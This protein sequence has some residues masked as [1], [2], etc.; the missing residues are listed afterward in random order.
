MQAGDERGGSKHGTDADIYGE[1]ILPESAASNNYTT[2]TAHNDRVRFLTLLVHMR[3]VI[4][5]DAVLYLRPNSKGETLRNSLLSLP[6]FSSNGFLAFQGQLLSAIEDSKLQTSII[7]SDAVADGPALTAG[8]NTVGAKIDQL[9][10]MLQGTG[11]AGAPDKINK[12]ELCFGQLAGVMAGV[13][14]SLAVREEQTRSWFEEGKRIQEGH[15]SAVDIQQYFN[16]LSP[17]LHTVSKN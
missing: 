7:R 15:L 13:L 5:Q 12:M 1:R 4:L 9:S 17:F 2:A 10:H 8:S 16:T 6:V 3:R 14:G 11:L